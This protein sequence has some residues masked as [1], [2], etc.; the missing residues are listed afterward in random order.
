MCTCGFFVRI[1]RPRD[2]TQESVDVVVFVLPLEVQVCSSI[3]AVTYN[4]KDG[5]DMSAPNTRTY[6]E[7]SE[8]NITYN[9]CW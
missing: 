4:Q 6:K 8:L 2:A 7:L 3:G 9:D 5:K 1:G